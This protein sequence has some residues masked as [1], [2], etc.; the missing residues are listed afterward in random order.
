M[1]IPSLPACFR[2][3]TIKKCLRNCHASL[4]HDRRLCD[5]AHP[6]GENQNG[7]STEESVAT[8]DLDR[9]DWTHLHF[10]RGPGGF[11]LRK[12]QPLPDLEWQGSE[13]AASLVDD[14]AIQ[15]RWFD[16][17]LNE[18]STENTP[19]RYFAYGE[20]L[21]PSGIVFRRAMTCVLP[22]S[23]DLT[24]LARKRNPAGAD[25]SGQRHQLLLISRRQLSR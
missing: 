23:R 7:R 4:C 1:W 13:I 9:R 19:G 10:R 12:G 22:D 3:S 15:T 24:A 17:Q 14:P 20:A 2:N 18:I 8:T 6:S 5:A 21:G 25:R 11:V 16:A